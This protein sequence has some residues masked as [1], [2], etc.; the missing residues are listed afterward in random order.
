[1]PPGSNPLM[2][3][4]HHFNDGRA[5]SR[6]NYSDVGASLPNNNKSPKLY[7]TPYNDRSFDNNLQN[8]NNNNY[9]INDSNLD[10]FNNDVMNNENDNNNYNIN[11]NNNN[12]N[13]SYNINNNNNNYNSNYNNNNNN[14]YNI[15]NN[16]NNYNSNY[17]DNNDNYN[18]SPVLNDANFQ[19]PAIASSIHPSS[20]HLPTEHIRP[21]DSY[22]LKGLSTL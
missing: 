9:N 17:R 13:N 5:P 21:S 7:A 8:Y 22:L 6:T 18:S 2:L 15:N 16:N 20:S 12:N 11:N 1:M 10:D 4:Q 3:Q 14:S 19:S